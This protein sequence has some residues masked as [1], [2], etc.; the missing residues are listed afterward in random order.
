L[1][2]QNQVIR[3]PAG[4]RLARL[5]PKQYDARFFGP[6]GTEPRNRYDSPDGGYKIFYAA[7]SLRGAVGEVLVR[8]PA[9][10]YVMMS[11]IDALASAT[12]RLGRDVVLAALHDE[13]MSSWGVSLT[14]LTASDYAVT[15]ALGAKIH[16]DARRLDGILYPSRFSNQPCI[17]LFERAEAALEPLGDSRPLRI[18]RIEKIVARFGKTVADDSL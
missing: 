15:Q 8:N 2:V 10:R 4:Q 1:G 3:V 9:R 17:A 12:F 7:F 13:R 5:H 16:A 11:E 14:D 6:A 18:E